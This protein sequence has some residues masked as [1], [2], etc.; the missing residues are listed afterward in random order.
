MPKCRATLLLA[1]A[2]WD[3]T[4]VFGRTTKDEPSRFVE[5]YSFN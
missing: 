1:W 3:H 4:L 5:H 2:M